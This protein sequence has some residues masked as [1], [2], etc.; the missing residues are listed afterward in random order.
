M[1]L[2]C[3]P[4]CI[5][6]SSLCF[7]LQAQVIEW[8]QKYDEVHKSERELQ[9]KVRSLVQEVQSLSAAKCT[10]TAEL[11]ECQEASK[12]LDMQRLEQIFIEQ[13]TKR[14]LLN[15]ILDLKVRSSI[16]NVLSIC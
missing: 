6:I 7:L 3:M 2:C 8:R 15:Q 13:Q 4:I 12:N 5:L 10:L 16:R 1:I 14:S 9:E 11:S